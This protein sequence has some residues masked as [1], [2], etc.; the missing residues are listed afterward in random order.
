M[1][2]QFIRYTFA[3]VKATGIEKNNPHHIGYY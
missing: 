3:S 2:L 1:E